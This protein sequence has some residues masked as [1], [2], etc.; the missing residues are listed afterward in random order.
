MIVCAVIGI[1]TVPSAQHMDSPVHSAETVWLLMLFTDVPDVGV[2][3][4]RRA[5][6]NQLHGMLCL[7]SVN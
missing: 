6:S 1:W 4:S 7:V 5:I 2:S 3:K